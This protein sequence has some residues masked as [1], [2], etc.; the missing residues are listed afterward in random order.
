M[1]IIKCKMCGGDLNLLEG[2]SVAECEYCGTRQ[3]V[4]NADNEKKL[5][6]FSRA[7]RLRAA[8]DFDKAAGIYESIIADF[9]EEAEAYWGLVLCKYGIEYVD[10]PATAKKVPTCHRSSFDSVL[11][12]TNYEQAMENA[13]LIAQS[14][15]RE[16]AKQLERLRKDILSVS[17][18][19]QPYDI[20]I[21]YKETDAAG[22]RTL[23][24]V[25][26]Q[27]LYSALT[28]KGYRV[29]FSRITLQGKLG[30]AYEPYI[31]A[32]LHSAKIMLA[33]GTRYEHYT[34]VWVKNEWSRYLKLCQQ[35]KTKHL[36]P[37]YKDIDPE[38]IPKE[39][40]H[41][42]GAD[43]GKMGAVQDILFNMEKYIPLKQEKVVHEQVIISEASGQKMASLLDRGHMAL[44]DGDFANADGFFEEVLN[45][46]SKNARAYLG[47]FLAN[48]RC[49]SLESYQAKSLA[50]I[51]NP[52]QTRYY[53]QPD[54]AHID[55][56]TTY[57]G[58]DFSRKY[59]LQKLYRFE[60]QYLSSLPYLQQ[61][62]QQ[63]LQRWQ[64]DKLLSKAVQFASGDFATELNK[65]REA[66]AEGFT[67]ALQNATQQE[68][69]A[70]DE[71]QAR[72]QAHLEAV[73][74]QAAELYTQEQV[75]LEQRYN[76][77]LGL[78]ETENSQRGLWNLAEKFEKMGNFRDAR[79]KAEVCREKARSVFY[80]MGLDKMQTAG[81]ERD[82]TNL[83]QHF[84]Q[85][86]GYRD[87]SEL[88]KQCLDKA[89]AIRAGEQ[90]QKELKE[91]NRI[92][93]HNANRQLAKVLLPVYLSLAAIVFFVGMFG[94]LKFGNYNSSDTETIGSI[95]GAF[96]IQVAVCIL[97]MVFC[98]VQLINRGRKD[99]M[100]TAFM[101]LTLVV[102]F[103]GLLVWGILA[104]VS[105][106]A[107]GFTPMGLWTL[108]AVIINL[109]SIVFSFIRKRK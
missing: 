9:P 74:K 93:V 16:E 85:L 11:E 22:G 31:F 75:A 21:C 37:C 7:G 54:Q 96:F 99:K 57:Y 4:P 88:A 101:V 100:A 42:Q 10:D 87:S 105:L 36:I 77:L 82:F 52:K 19:E 67:N 65:A 8:C 29:F 3:T 59:N 23:D 24:S 49:G 17:S 51:Q 32:A 18:A 15:Y 33:V 107:D 35:D 30:Q 27:D 62:Q 109:I 48:Q 5:T 103:I 86:N 39:F 55:R 70:A 50:G 108:A 97:P 12:D 89:A 80:Q 58:D 40:N 66:I 64:T 72:Y 104:T 13:D 45:Y 53:L 28:D 2:Q 44:E 102:S 68:Q 90:R 94:V 43:L 60:L 98:L 14:V 69:T 46:D 41:L 71:L 84:E 95:I 79:E 34:A 26:A 1:A 106:I 20:F 47:K 56:I 78:M 73:D 6:L 38:D 92:R 91:Q 25:L 83:S 61:I 81:S 76:E 63:E